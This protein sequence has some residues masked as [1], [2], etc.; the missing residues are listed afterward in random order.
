M[1][2]LFRAW[3]SGASE[4][5]SRGRQNAAPPTQKVDTFPSRKDHIHPHTTYLSSTDLPRRRS[6]EDPGAPLICTVCVS[7]S[8]QQSPGSGAAN[9]RKTPKLPARMENNLPQMPNTKCRKSLHLAGT[10]QH[11]NAVKKAKIPNL[12][13]IDESAIDEEPEDNRRKRRPR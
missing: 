4:S 6:T 1:R 12:G 11:E 13:K 8:S 2:S 7:P 10:P 3:G 5:L 9:A